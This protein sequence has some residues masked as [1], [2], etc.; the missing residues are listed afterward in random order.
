MLLVIGVAV[1]LFS[2]RTW[3]PHVL[4][5]TVVALLGLGSTAQRAS[6]EIVMPGYQVEVYASIDDPADLTFD[7]EGNLYVG[8]VWNY[9]KINRISPGGSKVE[10]YGKIAL[11]YPRAVEWDA[12]GTICGVPGSLLVASDAWPER[13]GYVSAILPKPTRVDVLR[14]CRCA[15]RCD[16]DDLGQKRSPAVF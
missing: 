11:G 16:G 1:L 7:P 12:E 14:P 13:Q 4:L 9:K 15:V 5:A 10:E 3:R 8:H 6:A 2:R